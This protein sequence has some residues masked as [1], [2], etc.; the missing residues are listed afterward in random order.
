MLL[1]NRICRVRL[2]PLLVVAL[3]IVFLV[4]APADAAITIYGGTHYLLPN[5][6]KTIAVVATGTDQVLGL[7]FVAQIGDGGPINGGS[8]QKPNIVAGDITGPGTI[9]FGKNSGDSP[10]SAG[11][12]IWT[13]STLI[14]PEYGATLP[15]QGTIAY[16]TIDTSGMSAGSAAYPLRLQ[17]VATQ[18]YGGSGLKTDFVSVIP[19][20]LD[21][22]IYITNHHGMDWN[23]NQNG[24]WTD[25]KWNG[26]PSTFPD[27]TV[28]TT[29][30]KPYTV[31]VRNVQETNSLTLGNNAKL[32]VSN[33]PANPQ[34]SLTAY[35][36]T[37]INSGSQVEVDG[38]LNAQNMSL[39]GTLTVTGGGKAVAGAITGNG[40]ISVGG[41]SGTSTL[42][43][44]SLTANTLTIGG[45]HSL[46]WNANA[47]GDWTDAK[48]N[49][50]PP[51]I[52]DSS[53]DTA[54]GLPYAVTVRNVQETHSLTLSNNAK[55][56]VS[57]DSANPQ[58][59]LRISGGTTVNTGSL[60]E[61]DGMLNAQNMSLLGTLTVTAGGQAVTRAITG[62]G[63]INVGGGAGSS[64][65]T[66]TSISAGTLTIG[67]GGSAYASAAA[68]VPEPG[69]FLLL[70]CFLL[71]MAVGWKLNHLMD[72]SG[73]NSRRR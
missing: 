50:S 70:G 73:G 21:G 2:L 68:V 25:A 72:R 53:A 16:L 59:S 14:D 18:I 57:N 65:L 38:T 71:A 3:S 24:D 4:V 28:N 56:L 41:G 61:V 19:S 46:N 58:N 31:T 51:L 29:I 5:S 44:T 42:T 69:T 37:T 33:D 35:G 9:F 23:A 22:T 12:L 63:A 32:V 67:R 45:F 66:A 40:A 49:G 26:T 30:G 17:N 39:Q 54:I 60:I 48:W 34:N 64:M 15:V 62:N 36:G 52:P 10:S 43:T 7:N 20:I 27:Y 8:T 55:L 1:I 11:N 6:R 47:S 13:D